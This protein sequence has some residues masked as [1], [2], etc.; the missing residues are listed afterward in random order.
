MVAPPDNVEFVNTPVRF[1]LTTVGLTVSDL[2]SA[3][4]K[5][6]TVNPAGQIGG[7]PAADWIDAESK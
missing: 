6:N 4:Q 5:Q 2:Q 7:E 1:P 3:I